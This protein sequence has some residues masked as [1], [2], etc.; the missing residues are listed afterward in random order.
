MPHLAAP[1]GP[2]AVRHLLPRPRY[3]LFP[4]L[5]PAASPTATRGPQA[6]PVATAPAGPR[7]PVALAPVALVALVP[8]VLAAL[9]PVALAA[10]APV[11]LAVLAPV[12]LAVP[13]PAVSVSSLLRPHRPQTPATARA[14][15]SA[16]RAAAP[17]ISSR[18]ISADAVMMTTASA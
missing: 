15:K 4:G 1:P 2:M 11:V 7:A 17:W 10:L 12:V 3:A 18:E 6:V 14:R 9:A 5:R 16:S 8:A 13:V